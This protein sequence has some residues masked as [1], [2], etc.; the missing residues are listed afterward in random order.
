MSCNFLIKVTV[1]SYLILSHLISS[2]LVLSCLVLS[3]LI[4]FSS[5]SDSLL[6]FSV[7][8][9]LCYRKI[10]QYINAE[11]LL[12]LTTACLM[13]RTFRGIL[14]LVTIIYH[15]ETNK[16]KGILIESQDTNLFSLLLPDGS[17][18]TLLSVLYKGT[19]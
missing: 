2:H 13:N 7:F 19:C 9:L 14:I 11:V 6:F 5:P 16:Q 8:R 1:L 17:S 3:Y 15:S 4:S 12:I 18:C 10:R